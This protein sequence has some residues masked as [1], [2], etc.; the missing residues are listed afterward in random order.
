MNMGGKRGNWQKEQTRQDQ[1]PARFVQETLLNRCIR[2]ADKSIFS[3]PGL[4]RMA[5]N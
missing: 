1:S 5:L 4:T 2:M 3:F